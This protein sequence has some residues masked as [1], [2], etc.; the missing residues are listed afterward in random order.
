MGQGG[1]ILAIVCCVDPALVALSRRRMQYL[2]MASAISILRQ[3]SAGLHHLHA[4]GIIHRDFRAANILITAREP[5]Q[6][7]VADFGV[8]HQLRAFAQVPLTWRRQVIR[9][10]KRSDPLSRVCAY[11]DAFARRVVG[12]SGS[13]ILTPRL[14]V[15]VVT[16]PRVAIDA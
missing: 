15:L 13:L 8:S 11:R 5:M 12:L 9:P 16:L 1:D 14:A 7:V 10:T 2:S 6:V 4:Q 3:C